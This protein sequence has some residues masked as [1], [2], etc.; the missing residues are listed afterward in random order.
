MRRL[1]RATG[2]RRP[3]EAGYKGQQVV[4]VE[5]FAQEGSNR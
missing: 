1:G 5:G 4:E 3:N 2:M